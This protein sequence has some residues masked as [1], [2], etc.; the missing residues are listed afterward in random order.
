MYQDT[1]PIFNRRH[2]LRKLGIGATLTALFVSGCSS[3]SESSIMYPT[4]TASAPVVD[5]PKAKDG[6]KVTP[7]VDIKYS[8]LTI[9]A[10]LVRLLTPEGVEEIKNAFDK[11]KETYGCTFNIRLSN[12]DFSLKTEFSPD[13]LTKRKVLAETKLKTIFVDFAANTK[14]LAPEAKYERISSSFIHELTH[15]CRIDSPGGLSVREF[16]EGVA[17]ALTKYL[18]QNYIAPNPENEVSA[19]LVIFAT[20]RW[21]SPKELAKIVQ[22]NDVNGFVKIFTGG[23]TEQDRQTVIKYFERALKGEID[24]LNDDII[25]NH[26]K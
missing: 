1:E 12:A 11:Y 7:E 24:T 21:S 23:T 20:D 15:A 14:G 25:K 6:S 19:R 26:K 13:G 17:D 8:N 2:A 22:N 16:N 18:L 5:T 3:N 9:S 10:D 4:I